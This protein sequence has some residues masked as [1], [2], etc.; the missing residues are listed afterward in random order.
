MNS[1]RARSSSLTEL[2][3][4]RFSVL[5]KAKKRRRA[6]RQLARDLVFR[7]WNLWW[8]L[9]TMVGCKFSG[10]SVSEVPR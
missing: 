4:Q 7:P 9:G 8:S 3:M 2:G 10:R 6:R 1:P 5:R